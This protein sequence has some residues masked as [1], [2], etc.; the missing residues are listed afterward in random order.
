M[1]KII[2]LLLILVMWPAQVIYAQDGAGI[3]L[4]IVKFLSRAEGVSD[5]QA[6]AIGDIFTRML[7]QSSSITVVERDR[8]DELA[9][10]YQFAQS[11]RFKD[12]EVIQLGKI[13]S[14]KYMLMGAVTNMSKKTKTTDL[15][16][17]SET[18]QAITVTI[19][20]RIVDVET[21]KVIYTL[22]ENGSS[23]GKESGFNFYGF[24][25]KNNDFSGLEMAA[26]TEAISRAVFRIREKFAG[27]SV[28]VINIAAK[29]I[30]INAGKNW[31][32]TPGMLFQ[33]YSEGRE[34]INLDGTSMGK[35]RTILAILKITDVQEDFS[36]AQIIKNGGK[37]SSLR[38]GNR[39]QPI[40]QQEAD[41][42]IKQKFFSGSS[43]KKK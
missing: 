11:G 9:K 36:T 35:K 42:L 38:K 31:G 13:I 16:L 15:W 39:V 2:F 17:I 41:T 33:V 29:E 40:T 12:D 22:S 3:R 18:R 10:E 43:G 23:S 28:Q 5:K 32:I 6:E 7:N 37:S 4:G 21:S 30:A 24:Q 27:D 8:F 14:C 25:T 20:V 1:K 19:D 26:I 34:M